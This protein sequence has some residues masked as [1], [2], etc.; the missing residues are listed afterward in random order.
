MPVRHRKGWELPESKA[1]PEAVF[2]NR[3]SLLRTMGLG[4]M[5]MPGLAAILAA[6]GAS[7]AEEEADPSAR[8]YPFKRNPRYTLDRP[9]TPA[10]Y[11]Q[12]YNNFYEFGTDKAIADDA[13]A[14]TIRPWTV[15]IDGMVE[16]PFTVGIDDLLRKM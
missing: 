11:S 3:R 6:H 14:L 9:L 12:N 15:K 16:K 8:L 5:L 10:K 7:A 13:Q 2:L 4:S 1:T